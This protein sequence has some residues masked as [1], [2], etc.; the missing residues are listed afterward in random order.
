MRTA[1]RFRRE[2]R[3]AIKRWRAW[4]RCRGSREELPEWFVREAIIAT[5]KRFVNAMI[6]VIKETV[7]KHITKEMNQP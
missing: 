2:R 6:P 4:K 1:L 5:Q 7:E 3:R